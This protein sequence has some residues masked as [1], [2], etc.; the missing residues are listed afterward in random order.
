MK[1]LQA[2]SMVT[3]RNACVGKVTALIKS[4][5]GIVVL[6][7]IVMWLNN[8]VLDCG[9]SFYLTKYAQRHFFH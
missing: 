7:I 9:I 4:K 8:R 6:A 2:E 5:V 3:C 1:Q